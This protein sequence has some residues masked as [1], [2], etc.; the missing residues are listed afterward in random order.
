MD[1]I[2]L[3]TQIT[4]KEMTDGLHEGQLKK[5]HK[6]NYTASQKCCHFVF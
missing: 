5:Q 6:Y 3:T 2:K 1:L 4:G